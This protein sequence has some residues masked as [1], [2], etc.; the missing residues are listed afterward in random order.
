MMSRW[1]GLRQTAYSSVLFRIWQNACE[2]FRIYAMHLKMSTRTDF[3]R[4]R[5]RARS[6]TNGL[7][8]D[9]TIPT[10]I[11]LAGYLPRIVLNCIPVPD[12][13]VYGC[14]N[15]LIR[16]ISLEPSI[17]VRRN[18]YSQIRSCLEGLNVPTK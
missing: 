14:L 4:N 7:T 5:A 6:W 3:L 2:S 1:R 11:S 15:H 8:K 9:I 18:Y 13:S 17:E 12:R 16:Y 10:S